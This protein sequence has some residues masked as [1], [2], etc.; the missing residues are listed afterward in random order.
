MYIDISHAREK[1][2]AISCAQPMKKDHSFGVG[3]FLCAATKNSP[4]LGQNTEKNYFGESTSTSK[5]LQNQ[6]RKNPKKLAA[7]C[8]FTEFET[9]KANYHFFT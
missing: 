8:E 2:V 7:P 5:L 4:K 3:V 6:R 9:N 1:A